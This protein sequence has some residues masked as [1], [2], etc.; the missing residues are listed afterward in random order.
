[1]VLQGAGGTVAAD[2]VA[3]ALGCK[4][5]RVAGGRWADQSPR[6]RGRL[7]DELRSARGEERVAVVVDVQEVEG[8]GR[9]RL[10]QEVEASGADCVI[11][12]GGRPG[13]WPRDWFARVEAVINLGTPSFADHLRLWQQLVN[14]LPCSPYLP[15]EDLAEATPLDWGVVELAAVVRAGASRAMARPDGEQRVGGQDLLYGIALICY[16][17]GVKDTNH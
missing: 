6:A 14:G 11:A 17:Q 3:E 2:A 8:R 16:V 4:V 10:F 9:A 7:A 13:E 12:H 5:L 15:W 1:V